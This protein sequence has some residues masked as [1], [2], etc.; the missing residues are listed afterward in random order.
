[1]GV[2]S[3]PPLQNLG[4]C[5]HGGVITPPAVIITSELLRAITA[6]SMQRRLRRS[7]EGGEALDAWRTLDAKTVPGWQNA[8]D[9]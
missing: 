3:F 9:R 2:P 5:T 8:I 1:L 4:L 6:R 7:K